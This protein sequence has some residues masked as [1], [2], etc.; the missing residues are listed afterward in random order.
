MD[1]INITKEQLLQHIQG[2]RSLTRRTI[3]AFPEDKLFTF[4]IGEMRTFGEMCLEL[5]NMGVPSYKGAAT[6]EW[7]AFGEIEGAPLSKPASTKAE[8]LQMWDWS[9]D[10]ITDYFNKISPSRFQETD[11]AFG[12]WEGQVWWLLFYGIDNEIHH[13]GQAYVYLRELGIEPPHF[14]E[15]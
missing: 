12:Q 15:R 4:S 7:T 11:T 10:I 2:H 9:T 14:W 6:G 13:R 1:S 3:E 5:L 8:V